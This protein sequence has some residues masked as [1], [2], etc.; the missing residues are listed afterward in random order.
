MPQELLFELD[1]VRVTPYVAQFGSISYQIASI[2]SV[3]AVQHK[4][5]SRIAVAVFLLGAAL[6]IAAMLRSGNEQ[7]ADANFPLALTGAGIVLV[8]LLVQL[9]MPRRIYKL[10]LRSHG[11]DIEALT[12]RRSK[13]ILDVKQAI[14]EA[15]IAHAQR[16][17][18]DH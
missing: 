7:Q 2:G 5:L 14:E 15:F 4:R 18:R 1:D 12:S 16:T 13:F 6:L 11:G 3:R 9:I 8:A 10:I 17:G